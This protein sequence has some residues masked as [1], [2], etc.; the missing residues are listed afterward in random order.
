MDKRV[1]LALGVAM[2]LLLAYIAF[3]LDRNAD[4]NATIEGS[5]GS[6]VL[7]SESVDDRL[8]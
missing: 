5:S 7:R 6:D 3:D 8:E 1:A 4:R 2:A